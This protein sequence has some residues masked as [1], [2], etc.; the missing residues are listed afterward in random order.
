M[1]NLFNYDFKDQSYTSYMGLEN[2][3]I[4]SSKLIEMTAQKITSKEIRSEEELKEGVPYAYFDKGELLSTPFLSD[5]LK[6]LHSLCAIKDPELSKPYTQSVLSFCKILAEEANKNQKELN[7]IK[8][9]I[10]QIIFLYNLNPEKIAAILNQKSPK[11]RIQKSFKKELGEAIKFIPKVKLLHEITNIQDSD[12]YLSTAIPCFI[13]SLLITD[14]GLLNI[15]IIQIIKNHFINK[16]EQLLPYETEIEH[17]L[18]QLQDSPNLREKLES[19]KKPSTPEAPAN[20]WIRIMMGLDPR[21]HITNVIARKAALAALLSHVR[22]GKVNTCFATNVA[23]VVRSYNPLQCLQDLKSLIEQSKLTRTIKGVTVDFPPL[24]RMSDET[25]DPIISI[26]LSTG[27]LINPKKKQFCFVWDIPGIVAVCKAIGIDAPMVIKNILK[28]LCVKPLAKEVTLNIYDLIQQIVKEIS[29]GV[30]TVTPSSKDQLHA[31]ACFAFEA[32]TQNALQKVWENAIAGM[33]EAEESSFIKKRILSS[34]TTAF[35]EKLEEMLKDSAAD[36]SKQTAFAD[37]LHKE[38]LKRMRILFD[39]NISHAHIDQKDP[40][41]EG[42]FVL[43]TEHSTKDGSELVRI[44]TP[45]L[46]CHWLGDILASLSGVLKESKAF[47]DSKESVPEFINKLTKA[48]STKRFLDTCLKTYNTLN[49]T[50]T[51]PSDSMT[52]LIHTPWMDKTGNY[53]EEVWQVYFEEQRSSTGCISVNPSN[54]MDLYLN[55][56]SIAKKCCDFSQ[57]TILEKCRKPIP[58]VTPGIHAFSLMLGHPKLA[59]IWK[60]KSDPKDWLVHNSLNPGIEISKSRIDFSTIKQLSKFILQNFIPKDHAKAFQATIGKLNDKVS[61]REYRDCVLKS[62]QALSDM[63]YLPIGSISRKLDTFL[64]E[65]GLPLKMR[66]K[67]HSLVIP[68]ADT[69]WYKKAH[70]IYFCFYLN[71][72]NEN[73][74]VWQIQEDGTGLKSINQEKWVIKQT[75][76]FYPQQ[77]LRI[78]TLL[79]VAKT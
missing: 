6:C 41:A 27:K 48:L 16:K 59:L 10:G 52:S 74:E 28:S 11:S 79:G 75:W 22:Q 78:Q 12:C 45:E 25:V 15:G 58:L 4:D 30:L 69:H 14:A 43:Y 73:L 34:V 66:T 46:F 9:L 77:L 50:I 38:I 29:K 13:A 63:R 39:P 24:M 36:L 47:A 44:D 61:I 65:E 26:E 55:I 62:I 60:S 68:F 8:E 3:V 57:A 20:T 18:T 76:E 32:Q 64:S 53:A 71:P 31:L 23:I 40:S 54:A 72:G 7:E 37:E 42:A 35:Q 67:L 49:R 21:S 2:P 33:A 1:F 17:I 56:I 51:H 19:I 5:Q 70:D